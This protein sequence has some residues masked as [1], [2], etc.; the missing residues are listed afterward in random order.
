MTSG[1]D[2]VTAMPD[3]A[4]PTSR[5]SRSSSWVSNRACSSAVR[6]ATVDRRQW[7]A[8]PVGSLPSRGPV[9]PGPAGCVGEEPHHRLGVADVDGEQHSPTSE[10]V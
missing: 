6:S 5:P 3:T 4:A 8:R 1:T 7:W 2:E 10:A 9:P